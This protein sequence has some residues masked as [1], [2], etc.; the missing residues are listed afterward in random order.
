MTQL[1]FLENS[2]LKEIDAK[3]ISSD[4]NKVALDKTIFYFHSGGQ[5]NDLGKITRLSDGREFNII[6]VRKENGNVLHHLDLPGLNMGDIVKCSLDW[7]RRYLLMRYH[8]AMHLLSSIIENQA[9]ALITG[10][11]IDVGKTRVDFDLEKCNRE[12]IQT[13]IDKA[14]NLI[15]KDAKVKHYILPIAQAMKIPGVSKLRNVALKDL[16]NVRIV[17]IEGIDLQADGGTHVACLKE[18]GKI[19]LIKLDNKGKNNRRI[20]FKLA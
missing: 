9:K 16:D 7:D 6:D 5:P 19:E 13:Y 14:N 15:E 18:V 11:Q 20:Y 2:Y 4:A 8:T 10:N 1:T 3:V 17:E 12:I